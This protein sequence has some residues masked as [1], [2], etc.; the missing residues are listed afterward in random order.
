MSQ[1]G[2]AGGGFG[3]STKLNFSSISFA[4][5]EDLMTAEGWH[6]GSVI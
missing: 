4:K 2:G 5:I 3:T 6:Y 1:I